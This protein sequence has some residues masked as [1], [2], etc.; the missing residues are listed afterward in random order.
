MATKPPPLRPFRQGTRRHFQ[1]VTTVTLN[2]PTN[3][4]VVP[5]ILLPKV[6]M[7]SAI[8]IMLR[9]GFTS[10]AA[11]DALGVDGI[12]ALF[13]RIQLTAN[14]GSAA[15]IDASGKSLE[16]ISRF[17]GPFGPRANVSGLG[18]GAQ[19]FN[20]AMRVMVGANSGRNFELGLI[21]LQDP[22]IQVL[23]NLS[24]NGVDSAFVPITGGQ[25]NSAV[26][27]TADVFYEYYEI[28]DP[29]IFAL[30]PRAIVRTL[31]DLAT[32]LIVGDNIYQMPRLGTLLNY[33]QLITL[34][35]VAATPAEIGAFKIRFNKTNVIEERSSD[36]ALAINDY[37]YGILPSAET[38]T[39]T[40]TYSEGQ[41]GFNPGI[42]AFDFWRAEGIN[43]SGDL[44]DAIDT[45]EITTTEFI[46]NVVTGTTVVGTDTIRHVRRVV[47]IL[48]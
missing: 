37:D 19:T 10:P 16:S 40:P 32:G 9:G 30:P 20:Y 46:T 21:N 11:G 27:Y 5:P 1:R 33:C 31:E 44:R 6:G 18:V 13:Q 7:L 2:N 47:Q 23:L 22:Q 41:L 39:V 29:S 25:H 43:S 4:T 8:W 42:F 28:P 38:G 45:E 12:A 24:M 36:L 35:S 26:S 15:I 17:Q 14:L 34:N 48:P 3:A